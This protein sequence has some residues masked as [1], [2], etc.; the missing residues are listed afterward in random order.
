MPTAALPASLKTLPTPCLLLNRNR[1]RRNIAR[2]AERMAKLNCV[3]RPHVKTAKSIDVVNEIVAAGH[4]RGITVSTLKEAEYFFAA[5]ITD[6][7]Y[8]V[9]IAPNKLDAAASLLARG[10]QLRILLDSAAM[11]DIVATDGERRRLTY[12]VL[13][14]LDTDGHR[15][16]T[17]PEGDELLAIGRRLQ[18]SSGTALAGVL[19]HAGESYHCDTPDALAAIARQERDRAVLAAQRLRA[20]GLSCETVSIGST[21]T[22]LAIDDLSGVTEVRAGVYVFFDLV[23]AGLGLC[24]PDDVAVSVLATVIGHQPDKG[25][26]I[27]DAG[28]MAMSRDRGTAGQARDCGY[29]L[30][31]D[32]AERLM[33]GV[34]VVSCSQEHGILAGAPVS[35]PALAIGECVRVL[36]NH[37]CATAAM[38]DH[39]VVLDN[40]QVTAEWPRENGW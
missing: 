2:M 28:W 36:P 32:A 11:A 33:D 7:T 6:I 16:G 21:P 4:T 30:V 9:G 31:G 27:T 19:T 37:A 22:A 17:S 1:M 5:G 13:I 14:E 39:Y 25:W 8:A 18:A 29:G 24:T 40:G 38:Y 34:S 3:L 26:I 23:M 10:C 20:A 15:A 35:L 12:P